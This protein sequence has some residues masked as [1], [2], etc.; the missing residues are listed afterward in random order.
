DVRVRWDV[1]LDE[2]MAHIIASGAVMAK[3]QEG[4][5]VQAVAHGLPANRWLYYRFTALGQSS[6]IGRTRT[7]PGHGD[8]PDRMRC[9]LVS[10]QNYQQGFFTAYGDIAQQDVDFV[11][12]VGDY[13]YEDAAQATPVVPGRNHI[14]PEIFSVADYRNRYALYRLDQH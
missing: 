3:P 10:C 8:R 14:G 2:G 5:A 12:Q 11:F 9:A 4:H 1:A 7:F 13:I 6:R